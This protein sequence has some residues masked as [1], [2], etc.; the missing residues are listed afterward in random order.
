MGPGLRRDL[1]G[2]TSS[3]SDWSGLRATVAGIGIAGFAA[4]DALL[5]LGAQVTV[6]RRRG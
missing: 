5:D 1:T 3:A 2:L 4:A 6:I